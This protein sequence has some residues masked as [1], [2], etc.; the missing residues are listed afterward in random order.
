ML[1]IP[2]V[3]GKFMRNVPLIVI[4]VL[5]FSW[6]ESFFILPAH[7]A[8]GGEGRSGGLLGLVERAQHA[9]SRRF[10]RLIEVLYPRVVRPLLR[11]R[12]LTMATGL[13]PTAGVVGST[14]RFV[15]P[16]VES[17]NISC[18]LRMPYGTPIATTEAYAR[19]L[20]EAARDVL[21]ENGGVA[22]ISRIYGRSAELSAPEAG[23]TSRASTS[24][25][26][27]PTRARS[28]LAAS[29]SLARV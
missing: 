19:L 25:S 10:N 17:D 3:S 14:V 7:L 9:F 15:S 20:V 29:R 4:G 1:F 6:V 12:Y 2:G 8:H 5:I 26:S 22:E 27:P 24:S 28:R 18:D 16:R 23:A 13:H 21:E 11:V